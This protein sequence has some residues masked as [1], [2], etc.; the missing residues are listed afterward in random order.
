[1]CDITLVSLNDSTY[2]Q[3]LSELLRFFFIARGHGECMVM[4]QS[5]FASH[6]RKRHLID[7]IGDFHAALVACQE[8]QAGLLYKKQFCP[9]GSQ[10][11]GCQLLAVWRLLKR[12][13]AQMRSFRGDGKY[14]SSI[15]AVFDCP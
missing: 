15:C 13:V 9:V 10:R 8:L 4:K 3:N 1:M 2:V 11:T 6:A 7:S 12:N 14:R 5:C